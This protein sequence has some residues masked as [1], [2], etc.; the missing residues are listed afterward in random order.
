MTGVFLD[1]SRLW[2]APGVKSKW[3]PNEPSPCGHRV[4]SLAWESS[5]LLL[6]LPLFVSLCRTTT[7]HPSLL[8][9]LSVL[10][11]FSRAHARRE[12]ADR[13]ATALG[14]SVTNHRQSLLLIS[15]CGGRWLRLPVPG[16]AN[17]R[18]RCSERLFA[19]FGASAWSWWCINT[20]PS[21][22]VSSV[23]APSG[24]VWRGGL[25]SKT[26]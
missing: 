8:L 20:S 12:V 14:W 21:W 1:S 13:S 7:D 25:P 18:P 4:G 11:I 19:L 16:E 23:P 5:L 26:N 17:P 10:P 15:L 6:P 22:T 3:R 9:S 24:P 2:P